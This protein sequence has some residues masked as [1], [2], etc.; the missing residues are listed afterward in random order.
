M[1]CLQA[2]EKLCFYL[3]WLKSYGDFSNP[4]PKIAGLDASALP[5]NMIFLNNIYKLEIR[6]NL[7]VHFCREWKY[8]S[9]TYN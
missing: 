9:H 5:E 2:G 3:S 7:V 6:A 4:T 1:Y 8:I